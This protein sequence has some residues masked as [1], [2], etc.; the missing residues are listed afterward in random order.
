M[1]FNCADWENRVDIAYETEFF[2]QQDAL[3]KLLKG[4]GM[5]HDIA[6]QV[7]NKRQRIELENE[8]RYHDEKHHPGTCENA[9]RYCFV[10]E[11]VSNFSQWLRMMVD[12]SVG[13]ALVS[14]QQIRASNIQ[15]STSFNDDNDDDIN[16][17]SDDDDNDHEL[18][19]GQITPQRS[20]ERHFE[21]I[22]QVKDLEA[23][24][25]HVADLNSFK[26]SDVDQGLYDEATLWFQSNNGDI[27]TV[28][29][30]ILND[31]F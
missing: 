29:Q 21:E 5:V 14:Q 20:A 8:L 7:I 18:T 30:N 3:R 4:R 27:E 23:V 10:H 6:D 31:P 11:H 16:C 19:S 9:S 2:R 12:G 22:P 13:K 15:E 25:D 26:L 17:S 24:F 1:G 28:I